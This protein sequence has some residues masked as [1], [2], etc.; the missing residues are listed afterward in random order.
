MPAK[1]KTLLILDA[2]ALL[3]RSFH[4]LPPLQMKDGTLVNA[5]YGFI[6][7]LLKALK[8][9]KPAYIAVAFDRKT[10][11]FRHDEY[12][13]YKAKRVKAPQEFYDQIPLTH[14]VLEAFRIPVFEKD[15]FEADDIIGTIAKKASGDAHVIIATGDLD[16]L[17]L[18]DDDIK[19][20]TLRKGMGD[21][22]IY[23]AAAVKERYGLEPKQMIDYKALAGDQS[24]NIPGVRGIGEKTATDLL[25][26]FG[27]IETLYAELEKDTPKAQ[28]IKPGVKQKLIDHHKEAVMSKH[29]ATIVLDAP[30]DF[31]LAGVEAKP[32]DR[33]KV[34]TLFQKFEFKSLLARLP[35]Q[36]TDIFGGGEQRDAKEKEAEKGA[37]PEIVYEKITAKKKTPEFEIPTG[38]DET[39]ELVNT[40]K[41]FDLFYKKLK[42]QQEFVFD[43]ETTSLEPIDAKLLGISFS[44]KAG[45]AYYVGVPILEEKAVLDKLKSVLE[46]PDVKK[47]GHNMKYDI[48]VLRQVGIHVNPVSFDT[49]IASYLLNPGTRQH[50]L[51]SLAFQEFGYQMVPITALIGVGKKQISMD[52]VPQD[53]LSWYSCEDADY[54]FRL[55]ER[56]SKELRKENQVGLFDSIEL[57][58]VNVL[59][60]MELAG[61]KIDSPF[62][63]KLGVKLLARLAELTAEIY[64]HAGKEFNINSP[65][66]LKEILFEDLQ[67]GVDMKIK[68]TKTGLSTAASELE[69]L[70]GEHP[71]IEPLMEYRELSKLQ[72]TYVEALPRLVNKK[73]GRVHTSYNQ[74]VA[75]TGRLSSSDPNL[76]NI[77]IRSDLGAEIRKAFIAERGMRLISAD[78][79]QIE[80]RVVASLANDE[81]MIGSFRKGEDIHKRTAAD[82]YEIPLEDVTKEQRYAAKEVNFGVLY[83]MGAMGLAARKGITRQHAKEFIEKY[84]TVHHWIKEYIETTKALAHKLGYV[85]TLLGR[86]RYLPE[87]NSSMPQ[88]RSQAERMAVNMPVQGTAA[89]IMKMAMITVHNKLHSV[90]PKSRLLLQVH[91]ELVLE[92]PES[93]VKKVAKFVRD[94]MNTVY[95]LKVPIETEVSVGMNW[96]DMEEVV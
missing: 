22:V 89:D 88:V 19:V 43:T 67:V 83:G 94:T 68:R 53:K 27:N 79:S 87:I 45:E 28:A 10:P 18:I 71:I 15:K 78:Y 40:V 44:W 54:T 25:K 39:Y 42:D 31:S 80:L 11:T 58:L 35:T 51:D 48:A 41:D 34:F 82:V 84:F 81:K 60:D 46:D 55:Y 4:A 2:N 92:V 59:T 16:A 64:T 20:Y 93:D 37:E 26:T 49:M 77:P 21:T 33:D 17:Q 91:D 62:L 24:D 86:K 23:D 74:T 56:L 47:I 85:E 65:V 76:Q 1:K 38:G 14:D 90:S 6:T 12:K 52:A 13:E 32:Y 5:V 3:H 73:T 96:G 9:F 69:K 36:Q 8:E 63:N 61:I 72:S 57:P 7:T 70:I 75:A 95:K 66:Q 29:L 50:N 30:V